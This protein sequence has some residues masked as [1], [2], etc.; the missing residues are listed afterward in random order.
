MRILLSDTSLNKQSGRGGCLE[1]EIAKAIGM[2]ELAVHRPASRTHEVAPL[3]EQLEA[4]LR[5]LEAVPVGANEDFM[6]N[7]AVLARVLG[8]TAIEREIVT[9]ALVMGS[10]E[11]LAT[12][13][14]VQGLGG[15]GE[16]C[17]LAARALGERETDIQRA[18]RKD[19][20][21]RGTGLVSIDTES[22][23][24]VAIA[25]IHS[26]V[27]VI[28]SRRRT[29][30]AI[31]RQFV[32][33]APATRLDVASF[34]HAAEDVRVLV[35]LVK[36]ALRR[37][38]RGV[39]VLLHGPPGTGK[40]ELARVVA[41]AAG[42]KLFEVPDADQ[43]GD[44]MRGGDRL[45]QCALAQRTLAWAPRAVLVFDEVE[46]AF[47]VRWEGMGLVRESSGLKSWTHGLIERTPVPTFWVCNEIRQMDPAT[48]RRFDLVVELRVPPSEVRVRMLREAL[49][50]TTV[51]DAL[52]SRL[53]L[54]P[55]LT[56]AHVTRAVRVTKLMNARAPKDAIDA[57]S[58]VLARNLAAQGPARP[59]PTVQ[60]VCGPYELG[61]VNASTD[62]AR[63]TDA[64]VREKRASVC[65]YGPP[66]TG[67]TAWAKHLAERMGTPMRAARASDLL[68]CY[69]GGTEK[70]IAQ[71]F[72]AARDE[73]AVLF[74]DEADSFLQ[75]RAHAMRSW[76][77]TQVNELLVQ[78]EA[79][80]GVFVCATN[81]VDSLDRASLRR[82]A[83]K[84]EFR[85]LRA[86]S[87]W[88]MLLRL[89]PGAEDDRGVRAMI[90]RLD[91]LTPGDFAAV[92]RQ[93][94]LA[95]ASG[96]ARAM[97]AMLERELVLRKRG[98]AVAIGFGL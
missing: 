46:D 72:A 39:N 68:D 14:R 57:L 7:T 79:F 71:L 43:D 50:T 88:A 26:L 69:V 74:L 13:F 19:G 35:R 78:I 51:D 81:L 38:A 49:G 2:P 9:L 21:L 93:A 96:D 61:L 60:L 80:E 73:R 48:L 58:H 75:D 63:V 1:E 41:R 22:P 24:A 53:A 84:I 20:A 82:F 67:K 77:V 23:V 17:R 28:F 89:V 62:L 40:T 98:G 59:Q 97:V 11:G 64:I 90:E 15:F 87:R 3:R 6:R 45:G 25:P 76:E 66:G 10:V 91:G 37:R 94:K 83:L 18:L 8:L 55:R 44:A 42:A 56:P 32:R 52:L 34:T 65:L 5:E 30:R 12:L 29:A 54:D 4:R 36:G 16:V 47:S 86:E 27:D 33:E 70:N 85:A 95:G 31:M 92:S